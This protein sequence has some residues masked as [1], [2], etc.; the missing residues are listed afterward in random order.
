MDHLL[1][2]RTYNSNKPERKPIKTDEKTDN[3]NIYDTVKA[4]IERGKK[5]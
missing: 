4:I 3:N 2:K 5:R 1:K